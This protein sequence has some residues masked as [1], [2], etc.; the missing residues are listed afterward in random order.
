VVKSAY[1]TWMGL[2]EYIGRHEEDVSR[3]K[4]LLTD[5]RSNILIYVTGHGGDEFLKVQYKIMSVLYP[6]SPSPYFLFPS[7]ALYHFVMFFFYFKKTI[8]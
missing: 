8:F 6:R 4:R 5:D 7:S 3:S 2:M 1:G